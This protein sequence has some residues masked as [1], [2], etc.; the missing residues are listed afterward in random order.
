MKT[1]TAAIS[2]GILG[3]IVGTGW[4]IVEVG[5]TSAD[6]TVIFPDARQP[7]PPEPGEAPPEVQIDQTSYDFGAMERGATMSHDFKFTNAGKGSLKLTVGETTCKCTVGEVGGHEIGPGKSES[8]RLEWKANTR[9]PEFR[10]S[11][12]ILTNDPHRRRVSLTVVGQV[13]ERTSVVPRDL[14]LGKVSLGE[15]KS[16]EVFFLSHHVDDFQILGHEFIGI[17]SSEH[18]EVSVEPASPSDLPDPLAKAGYRI[19]LTVKETAPFG[20]VRGWLR[21]KTDLEKVEQYDI[22]VSV[23]VI[24]DVS[25]YGP[26]YHSA[27]GVLRLGTVKSREGKSAKLL[28]TVKGEGAAETEIRVVETSPEYLAAELGEPLG[29]GAVHIPV[30]IRVPPG[31]APAAFVGGDR[32]QYGRVVLETSHP[33]V[34]RLEIRV[35]FTVVN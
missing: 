2:C 29:G 28:V 18:F 35:R 10:Q 1:T 9:A 34:P 19:R 12:T 26:A 7:T 30:T 8:V 27:S 21:L 25:I 13:T 22:P 14:D 4:A 3:I 6:A 11:A 15:S 23:R 20:P 16:A 17:D 32:G 24:A 5:G 33:K 31:V